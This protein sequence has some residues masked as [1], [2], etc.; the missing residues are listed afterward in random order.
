MGILGLTDAR[1]KDAGV[2]GFSVKI[3]GWKDFRAKGLKDVRVK[4]VMLSGFAT[5]K[6]NSFRR[7]PGASCLNFR[8][9]RSN[10]CRDAKAQAKT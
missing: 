7:A 8:A 5:S 1:L 6:K 9:Y 4:D 3:L 2:K 10:H